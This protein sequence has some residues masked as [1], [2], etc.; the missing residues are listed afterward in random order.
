[1]E[2]WKYRFTHEDSFE[3]ITD[4]HISV[5]LNRSQAK[6]LVLHLLD[7]YFLTSRALLISLE[8]PSFEE[9]GPQFEKPR[10]TTVPPN[11]FTPSLEKWIKYG[12]RLGVS[13]RGWLFT[14]PPP[15]PPASEKII[16]LLPRCLKLSR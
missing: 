4:V 11:L 15:P 10:K 6:Q 8:F 1:M 13:T 14:P 3:L 7:F 16:E 12:A 5:D 2:G 9:G